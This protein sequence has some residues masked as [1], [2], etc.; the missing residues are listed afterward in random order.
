MRYHRRFLFFLILSVGSAASIMAGPGQDDSPPLLVIPRLSEA[1]SLEDFLEMKPNRRMEGR[2]ARVEGF[3]QRQPSD[4]SPSSQRTHVYSAYDDE[5]LYLVFVCFDSEPQKIRARM[6]RRDGH[7]GDDWIMASIDTFHDR[8]RSYELIVN[9]L[10]IQQDGRYVEGVGFD[11]SFDTLWHSRGELTK[12]GYVVWVAIPFRSLRFSPS[13]RQ[14]WGIAFWRY[15]PRANEMSTWPRVSSRVE[16]DLNQYATLEGLENVSPGRHVQLIPYGF[17]RSFRSLDPGDG[18]DPRF[19]SKKGEIDGGLD[20]KFVLKDSFAVDLAVNPD[21]SQVESDLPQVTVN[22]RFE[23]FFPE[24]RPFFLENSSFFQT[25]ID[26]FFSRRIQDLRLGA[27]LTGQRGPWSIGALLADDESPG[28]AVPREDPLAGA[29][30]RFAV[31][32]VNRDLFDQSTLGVI[33]TQRDLQGGFNRLGG[34]DARLKLNDNWVASGQAVTSSTR[35]LDGAL[36]AGPA[37][38]GRLLRRGRQLLYTL[39]YSDRSSGFLT[40]TGFL[41]GRRL[42]RLLFHRGRPIQPPPLR[43]DVR[44]VRQHVDFRFRPEGKHLISWGPTVLTNGIWDH[45]GNRL[46]RFYDVGLG[47]ELTGETHLEL[48]H[49]EDRELLRPGDVPAQINLEEF[50]H[51]RTGLFF[52]TNTFAWISLEAQ[53]S[54]GT[55]INLVPSAS[56]EPQLVQLTQGNLTLTLRP[57]SSLRNENAYLLERLTDRARSA[58][59]LNNHILRSRWD[60]QLNR[61]LALRF[62]LQYETVLSNPDLTSLETSKN[63][64]GDFLFTYQVNP[65]TALMWA[66]T[67]T[68]GTGIW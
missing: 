45:R 53:F 47:W 21:F 17:F 33:Y 50:S 55:G 49:D 31:L 42:R 35:L 43:P 62:I 12:K 27:R 19:L 44:S 15:I 41:P 48:F 6:T 37:Y 3:I 46:H 66:T 8:L 64:N 34:V 2:L 36:Q 54:A 39:D 7:K 24:K 25:P 13:Q 65:W 11:V 59:V 10:G 9:P 38:E 67:E 30:A 51:H 28:K 26:L 56:R 18:A 22:R 29:R 5:S 63:F 32:R 20:A 1:P 57:S 4:G 52:S 23:V 61:D 40:Q 16:G 58:N 60:W 68:C 14:T